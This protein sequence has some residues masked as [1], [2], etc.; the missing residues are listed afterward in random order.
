[1]LKSWEFEQE[2][3][4][5]VMKV[6]ESCAFCVFYELPVP[7]VRQGVCVHSRST[8]TSED[9]VTVAETCSPQQESSPLI[10][11]HQGNLVPPRDPAELTHV[12]D[13][14]VDRSGREHGPQISST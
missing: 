13:E 10:Y 6:P 4:F 2:L 7:R 12:P 14:D 9:A 1:M 8:S 5:S 3:L 11:S